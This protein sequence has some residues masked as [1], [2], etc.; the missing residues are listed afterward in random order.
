MPEGVNV[1][2]RSKRTEAVRPQ[3]GEC[4]KSN[5]ECDGVLSVKTDGNVI[6]LNGETDD[7]NMEDGETLFDDGSAQV[8]NIRD[9]GQ[10]TA[11]DN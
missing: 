2:D 9:Q 10:P 11:H 8:R 4:C 3:F 7:E 1:D 6:E 5:S